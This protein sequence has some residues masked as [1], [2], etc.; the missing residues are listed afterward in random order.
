ML[1]LEQLDLS[2]N[3]LS[4][5]IPKSLE[6]L[7]YLTYLDISFNDLHGEVPSCGPFRNCSS[8]SFM[9]NE[10]LC[11]DPVYGLRSCPTSR[12]KRRKPIIAAVVSLLGITLLILII[13]ALAIYAIGR[14]QRKYLVE[15]GVDFAPVTTL[16]VSYYEILQATEG[17]TLNNGRDV[18]VK[19]FN[20][21]QQNA[22][23]SFDVECEVLRSLRHRDL[24]K[25]IST[26][27]NPDF[28][29]LVLEYMSNGSLGQWLYS[30]DYVLDIL[31]KIN[32]MTDL[33]YAFKYLHYGYSMPIVHCDLKLS[34]VLLDEDLVAHLSDFGIDKLLG[35]GESN[36]YTT[37]L[38]TLGYIAPEYGLEGSVSIRCDI[39]SF[40]IMLMEV[41][42]RMKPSD[43]KFS[44]DLN[45]E[46]DK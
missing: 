42:T 8:K 46:L 25:V 14:C 41:F 37:T 19:V 40:G 39:Y 28:K 9:S 12:Q 32:I 15:N 7:K 1:S 17:G 38:G 23:K 11:G 44:G 22:F 5:N 16:R 20:L 31:Q 24:C 4:G 33:V 30:D 27:S 26:C 43:E 45:L 34:N 3:N 10:G 35:E 13:T 21:Q 36:A 6:A 2:H 29:A 18:V